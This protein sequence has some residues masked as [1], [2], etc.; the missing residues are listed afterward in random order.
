MKSTTAASATFSNMR[1]NKISHA[2]CK[3]AEEE[4][5]N[6]EAETVWGF[7]VW[8][9]WVGDESKWEFPKIGDPNI[10]P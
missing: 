6:L 8:L 5:G 4:P 10:V 3:S 9:L 7:G 2:S 1:S